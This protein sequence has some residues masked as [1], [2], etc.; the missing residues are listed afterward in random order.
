MTPEITGE[1]PAEDL[2]PDAM[3]SLHNGDWEQCGD[4]LKYFIWSKIPDEFIKTG[5]EHHEF[6]GAPCYETIVVGW[7][8]P[9][10]GYYNPM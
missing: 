7:E 4:C 3:R 1:V 9:I 2:L 8:C 5:Q 6:W 10:C